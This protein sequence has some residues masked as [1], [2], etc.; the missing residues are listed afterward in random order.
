MTSDKSKNLAIKVQ[1][2]FYFTVHIMFDSKR[3]YNVHILYILSGVNYDATSKK[4][5]GG[6]SCG[7]IP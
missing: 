3:S 4:R 1:Y 2:L 7:T 5:K 6:A